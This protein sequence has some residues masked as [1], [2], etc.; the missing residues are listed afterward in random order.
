MEETDPKLPEVGGPQ[1][2]KGV[3]PLQTANVIKVII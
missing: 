2:K 3:G 1:G